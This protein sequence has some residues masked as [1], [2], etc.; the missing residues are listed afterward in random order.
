MRDILLGNER[1]I[2][3]PVHGVE[4]GCGSNAQSIDK[5]LYKQLSH[6]HRRLLQRAHDTIGNGR[7]QEARIHRKPAFPQTEQR[8]FPVHIDPAQQSTQHLT[9]KGAQCRT[10]DPQHPSRCGWH[11]E[12]R[13]RRCGAHVQSAGR[14]RNC[15]MRQ[16]EEED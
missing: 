8:Y 7:F 4:S 14:N 11:G 16:R 6:L 1:I 12:P 13:M 2:V 9:D 3:R 10:E 15:G 5:R